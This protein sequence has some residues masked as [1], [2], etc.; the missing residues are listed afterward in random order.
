MNKTLFK[1]V[2]S[3]N[4]FEANSG[5]PGGLIIDGSYEAPAT[6]TSAGDTTAEGPMREPSGI[7][8]KDQAQA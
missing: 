2:A 8:F 4:A 7:S 6:R 5:L 1:R 3:T